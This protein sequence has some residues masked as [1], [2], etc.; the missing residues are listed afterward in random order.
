M[1]VVHV[2]TYCTGGAAKACRRIVG[3]L[4]GAG[5]DA[6][7]LVLYKTNDDPDTIDI[8]NE[9]GLIKNYQLKFKNKWFVM[10]H[11]RNFGNREEL[12]SSYQPVW[13]VE[14]NSLIKQ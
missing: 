3:A 5:T 7:M 11:E 2:N 8:R 10:S 1:K 13:K 12:F 14:E 4:V 6:K 9:Y